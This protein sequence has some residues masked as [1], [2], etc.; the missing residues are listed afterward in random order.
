M[1][2]YEVG[3]KA[4]Q[5]IERRLVRYQAAKEQADRLKELAVA[6]A[7]GA[8]LARH[9]VTRLST[10]VEVNSIEGTVSVEVAEEEKT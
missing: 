5:A 10:I 4:A 1:K 7:E 3:V 2:T 8:L 9:D 6:A